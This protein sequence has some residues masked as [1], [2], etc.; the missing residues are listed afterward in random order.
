[1]IQYMANDKKNRL[2]QFYRKDSIGPLSMVRRIP[3]Q[4]CTW[5]T[6]QNYEMSHNGT[7]E[8]PEKNTTLYGNGYQ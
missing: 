7:F 5:D 6:R 4:K 1:M 3:I 8:I 2:L